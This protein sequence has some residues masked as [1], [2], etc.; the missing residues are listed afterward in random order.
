MCHAT[1][2]AGAPRFGNGGEWAPR[3]A[4]GMDALMVSALNGLNAMPPRGLCATCSDAEL[5]AAVQYM[6]DNSK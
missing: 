6:V 4:K 5:Q 3:I 1:G 2:A